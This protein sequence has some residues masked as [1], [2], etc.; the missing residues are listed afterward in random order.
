MFNIIVLLLLLYNAITEIS[1]RY[2]CVGEGR[3][4]KNKNWER[5][6]K[7]PYRG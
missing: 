3:D 1:L 4:E 7:G 6:V 2:M 5:K